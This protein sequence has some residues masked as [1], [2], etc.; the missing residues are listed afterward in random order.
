MSIYVILLSSQ[1]TAAKQREVERLNERLQAAIRL[2]DEEKEKHAS[3]LAVVNAER[4]A[5]MFAHAEEEATRQVQYHS[6]NPKP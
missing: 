2:L 1:E 5:A 6:L 3:A 4:D